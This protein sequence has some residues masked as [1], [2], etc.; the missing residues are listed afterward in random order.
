MVVVVYNDLRVKASLTAGVNTDT[1]RRKPFPSVLCR[2]RS[3]VFQWLVVIQVSWSFGH[4]YLC[5]SAYT[6][7]SLSLSHSKEEEEHL[8]LYVGTCLNIFIGRLQ[9]GEETNERTNTHARARTR[10]TQTQIII[11]H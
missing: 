4:L 6:F 1:N 8:E 5:A 10:T 7:L 2:R 11:S 9:R 3:A